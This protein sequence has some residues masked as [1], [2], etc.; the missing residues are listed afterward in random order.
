MNK[1]PLFVLIIYI[2]FLFFHSLSL[3]RKPFDAKYWKDKY[4]QS[5]WKNF[6]SNRTIGDDGLYTHIGYQLMQG[7]DPTRDNAEMPP[8]GKYLIGV[9]IKLLNNQN[10]FGMISYLTMIFVFYLLIKQYLHSSFWQYLLM[11]AFAIDPLV[12]QQ[13][14]IVMLDAIYVTFIL[15][16]FLF[17]TL[18]HK[19][20]QKKHV[21]CYMVVAGCALGFT[22]ATK[23]P[24][25]SIL[26]LLSLLPLY[27]K[28]FISF[29]NIF[30]IAA[31]AGII[32][33]TSYTR[34]FLNGSSVIDFLKIQKWML[35]FYLISKLPKIPTNF[36]TTFCFG[37]YKNLFSHQWEFSEVW[38]LAWPILVISIFIGL[39]IWLKQEKKQCNIPILTLITFTALAF[40]FYSLTPFWTRYLLV[41]LPFF[42]LFSVLSFEKIIKINKSLA[43]VFIAFLLIG[44]IYGS[45]TVLFPSPQKSVNQF[46][47]D[48]KN[49]FFQDMYERISKND[50]TL[51]RSDFH[52]KGLS[53]YYD[54]QIAD[55]HIDL[56]PDT[57][58]SRTQPVQTVP[59]TITYITQN[60]G[61]WTE[62]K[63]LPVVKEEDEWKIDWNWNLLFQGLTDRTTIQTTVT[64]AF[65]G[66]IKTNQT[67][68]A[69]DVPGYLI[70]IIPGLIENQKESDMLISL[71]NAFNKT[72]PKEFIHNRYVTNTL[73][74]RPK[75][76]GVLPDTVTPE[77]IKQLSQYPAVLL[78]PRY[79]R[80]YFPDTKSATGL[81]RNML[82]EETTSLLYSTTSYDGISG[83]ELKY[84]QILKGKNGGS[85]SIYDAQNNLVRT[86]LSVQKLDGSDVILD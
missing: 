56:E 12:T 32:Y 18:L 75:S 42:Y 61:T 86:I 85:I 21:S 73:T 10:I 5:Q 28:R 51:I 20:P 16:Y 38:S 13:H 65:R 19:Y 72:L 36:L 15:L 6:I 45:F 58:W 52:T 80:S 62:K 71:E 79:A 37:H 54:A 78:T 84:N 1:I 46:L 66:A 47:Y 30:V 41:L 81:V 59:L 9:T 27:V 35:N 82:F 34:F 25:F 48:W 53:Y 74:N 76:I 69:Q 4:E 8:L 23:F 3:F 67:I 31:T 40:S 60:L 64:P 33:A 55:V 70:S 43:Y 7:A 17:I 83:L 22:S 57:H 39:L 49:G 77:Q 68:Y 26:L 44:N 24:A 50:K 2:F 14:T 11:L 29:K 63:A